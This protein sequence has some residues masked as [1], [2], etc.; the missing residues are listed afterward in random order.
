M[1]SFFEQVY[2]HPV[3]AFVNEIIS[4]VYLFRH[5]DISCPTI[6]TLRSR[7]RPTEY[8]VWQILDQLPEL[9]SLDV[10]CTEIG[11]NLY[12]HGKLKDL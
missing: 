8:S 9:V 1:T 10:S 11:D 5:L 12:I 4:S 6:G 7:K 3:L 2:K